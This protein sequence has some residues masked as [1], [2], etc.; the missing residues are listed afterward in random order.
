MVSRWD[1]LEGMGEKSE[2][3]D[4]YKLAVKEQSRGC[5]VHYKKIVNSFLITMDGVRWVC[6]YQDDHLVSHIMF[7]HWC[8]HLKL[9]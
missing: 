3:I 1:G 7:Y 5:K 6:I 4:K 9:K 8:V 2:G